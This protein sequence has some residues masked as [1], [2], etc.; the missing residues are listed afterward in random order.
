MHFFIVQNITCSY[1]MYVKQRKQNDTIY[2]HEGIHKLRHL[3]KEG[4]I[5]TGLANCDDRGGFY[6][7]LVEI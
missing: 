6:G 7:K 2:M 3:V 4:G 1:H 5:C